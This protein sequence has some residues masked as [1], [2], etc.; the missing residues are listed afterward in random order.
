M[1][2]KTTRMQENT[3]VFENVKNLILDMRMS[4]FKF[5]TLSEKCSFGQ[6]PNENT[7]HLQRILK[8]TKSLFP[9]SHRFPNGDEL[10]V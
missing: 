6:F 7:P 8:K 1:E 3:S 9:H 2:K 10:S 4:I 5:L